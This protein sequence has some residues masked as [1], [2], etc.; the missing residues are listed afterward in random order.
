MILI[1]SFRSFHFLT[2]KIDE[3]IKLQWSTDS[4]GVSVKDAERKHEVGTPRP[5][6]VGNQILPRVVF[7]QSWFVLEGLWDC[8]S[9]G[10]CTPSVSW[11]PPVDLSCFGS[12]W[13]PRGSQ[14]SAPVLAVSSS[15]VNPSETKLRA[16]VFHLQW[17][18]QSSGTQLQSP[19]GVFTSKAASS[20]SPVLHFAVQLCI[21]SDLMAW[22]CVLGS[23][24][25]LTCWNDKMSA[26]PAWDPSGT[27]SKGSK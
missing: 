18:V 12:C 2:R 15:S 22:F 14:S 24:E 6:C 21:V 23:L 19:V 4:D 16:Q 27:I 1:Q 11:A 10:T 20:T 3:F 5:C 25:F 8:S 7:L 17:E 26:F 9:P 13:A